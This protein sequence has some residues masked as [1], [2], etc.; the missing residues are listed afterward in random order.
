MLRQPARSTLITYKTNI[1]SK[2][3]K[4]QTDNEKGTE[5]IKPK[6]KTKNTKKKTRTQ[7]ELKIQTERK[8]NEG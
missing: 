7:K 6:K 4:N 1:R 3:K 2:I 8:R 5:E